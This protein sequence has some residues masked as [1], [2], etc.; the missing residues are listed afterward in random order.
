[1][2]LAVVPSRRHLWGHPGRLPPQHTHCSPHRCPLPPLPARRPVLGPPRAVDPPA[3]V[4]PGFAWIRH[5]AR[6]G[7]SSGGAGFLRTSPVTIFLVRR[8]APRSAGGVTSTAGRFPPYSFR[9]HHAK[10]VHPHR[11]IPTHLRRACG[12]TS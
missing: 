2:V 1:M 4:A 11:D 7:R 9:V 10:P 12:V 3:D 8:L 6:G 5:S